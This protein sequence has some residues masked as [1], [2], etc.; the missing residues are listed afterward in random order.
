MTAAKLLV[1]SGADPYWEGWRYGPALEEAIRAPKLGTET[2][3]VADYLQSL[4]VK[5]TYTEWHL[6][7]DLQIEFI[8]R[9]VCVMNPRPTEKSINETK[10]S[11]FA[12]RI[13]APRQFK[14]RLLFTRGLAP[15]LN[16]E[17]GVFVSNMWPFN[18]GA[19]LEER[20]FWPIELLFRLATGVLAGARLEH[21]SVVNETDEI[22]K[23]FTT[24]VPQWIVAESGALEAARAMG[25]WDGTVPTLILSPVL[26]KKRYAPG[27]EAED[28]AVKR[29]AWKW[30]RLHL[31]LPDLTPRGYE[32][33]KQLDEVDPAASRSGGSAV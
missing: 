18:K 29:S 22:L 19:F 32:Y 9:T 27:R 24:P 25:P 12:A 5:P 2:D 28:Q 13:L 23:G 14:H 30:E 33:L 10:L 21:G 7:R 31:P 20:F 4:G 3:K 17:L 15:L 26:T 11:V 16:A 8:E 6:W 1:D